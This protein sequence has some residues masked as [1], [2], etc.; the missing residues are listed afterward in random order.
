MMVDMKI[1]RGILIK[2]HYHDDQSSIISSEREFNLVGIDKM[3]E[4]REEYLILII[5]QPPSHEYLQS[6]SSS[7]SSFYCKINLQI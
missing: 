1:R 7:F 3:K 2:H 6:H 5:S 4:E